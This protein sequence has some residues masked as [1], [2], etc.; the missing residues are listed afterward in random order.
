MRLVKNNQNLHAPEP[1]STLDSPS[2]DSSSTESGSISDESSPER[3]PIPEKSSPEADSIPDALGKMKLF[4]IFN[5]QF[6][7]AMIKNSLS[8]WADII[9][10]N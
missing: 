10:Q 3:G 1:N 9:L 2:P 8:Y 4:I 7:K 6:F 5:H